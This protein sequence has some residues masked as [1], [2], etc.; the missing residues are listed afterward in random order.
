MPAETVYVFDACAV[1]ALLKTEAGANVV[2]DLLRGEGNRC[3]VHAINVCEIYYDL[4]RRDGEE[5]ADGLEEILDAY[6][7]ELAE[8]VP[9]DLWRGAGKLKGHWGRISLADCFALALAVQEK[10]TLVTSDHHE[11]DRLAQANVCPFCF[12]R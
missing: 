11:L 5:I 7:F 3:L 8:E 1:V 9:S 10:G 4:Y 6:G 2:E 12:I